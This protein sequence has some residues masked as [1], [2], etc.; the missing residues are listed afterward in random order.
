MVGSLD[1]ELARDRSFS[2]P[3]GGEKEGKWDP[4]NFQGNLGSGEILFRNFIW[5]DG[6]KTWTCLVGEFFLNKFYHGR[7][8]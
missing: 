3:N 1:H 7:S 6:F 8:P 5:P 4:E 2:P